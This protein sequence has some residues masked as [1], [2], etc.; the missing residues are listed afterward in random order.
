MPLEGTPFNVV[1]GAR[2]WLLISMIVLFGGLLV[3]LLVASLGH[4]SLERGLVSW[5]RHLRD[6]VGDLAGLSGR[7]VLAL[8][9]HAV[10]ESIHRKVL[11][12]F[13]IFAVLFL[14]AGWYLDNPTTT[15]EQM[16]YYVTFVLKASSWLTLLVGLLLS[17]FSLPTDIRTQT[18]HT[19][20]TKPVR[21]S[22]I[23]LGR[24]A[25]FTTL[26]TLILL[27]MGS[28]SLIFVVRG[29]NHPH[30]LDRGKLTLFQGD[31]AISEGH[32]HTVRLDAAGNGQTDEVAGHTHRVVGFE[33]EAAESH[34]H[35]L[36]R[37]ALRRPSDQGATSEN[38]GHLHH[39]VVDANGN[40]ATDH[41]LGHFH[42]IRDF[43][44]GRPQDQ[45]VARV[46]IYG[47]VSFR[48]REGKEV[49]RGVSVGH[50]WDYRSYLEG[51]TKMAAIW[52]FRNL[53][54]ENLRAL[55]QRENGSIS[56]EMT[57]E[58]YRSY[59]GD[60]TADILA[61]IELISPQTRRRSRPI[62]VGVKE[63]P[64][65]TIQAIPRQ[66]VDVEG[67]PLDLFDDLMAGRELIVEVSCA[68]PQQYLGMAQADLYL[69][70]GDG[71]FTANFLKS[72]AG[73]WLQMFLMICVGVVTSTFLSG[74]VAGLT[75]LAVIL[76]GSIMPFM[77]DVGLE[78]MPGALESLIRL[79]GGQGELV[80]LDPNA[81]NTM[82]QGIDKVFRHVIV[83][84]TYVLP[85][86]GSLDTAAFVANGFDIPLWPMPELGVRGVV[87]HLLLTIGYCVPYTI[88]GYFSIKVREIAR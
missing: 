81:W 22:E 58:V 44:V 12:V 24:V 70:A 88:L 83:A 47:T 13:V 37:G 57:L 32:R 78:K 36:D 76:G 4:R 16:K 19:V 52:R 50:V 7:R 66:L 14:F 40:G 6:G 26:G 38:S 80:P 3:G 82:A 25:G 48:N 1:E 2:T 67:K 11:Y 5:F 86:L 27:V 54:V 41:Q 18:I 34:T 17:C 56:M 74:P 68:S 77:R 51:G 63:A 49:D 31:T 84:L 65:F 28:V 21:R 46:P 62:V 60:V 30:T 64:H 71:S 23:V 20:I 45:L 69:R 79:I 61:Q 10:K 35:A 39:I 87:L 8:A 85:D 15:R 73:V 59:K 55:A 42:E 75:T 53:P 9:L 29:V 33:V 43:S 72:L